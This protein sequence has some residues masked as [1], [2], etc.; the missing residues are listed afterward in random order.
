MISKINN[1]TISAKPE[2]PWLLYP[3]TVAPPLS[4]LFYA[5]ILRAYR[6]LADYFLFKS[7]YCGIVS[8]VA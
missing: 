2:E 5:V 1:T 8:T 3:L 4:V 6:L 7:E